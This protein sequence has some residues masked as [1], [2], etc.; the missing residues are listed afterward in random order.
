MK[1]RQFRVRW[2][3][4]VFAENY[5]DA[6]EKA[7]RAQR[8]KESIATVFE[9]GLVNPKTDRVSKIQEIDLMDFIEESRS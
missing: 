6:A 9:I 8:D 1:D 2:E 4:D 3:I 5:R 7:L